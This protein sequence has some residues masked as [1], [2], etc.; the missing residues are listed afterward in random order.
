MFFHRKKSISDRHRASKNSPA[1]RLMALGVI[2][3]VRVDGVREFAQV[4]ET[5]RC[6]WLEG[7]PGAKPGS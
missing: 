1:E 5:G 4:V 2:S 3:D 6:H 7:S